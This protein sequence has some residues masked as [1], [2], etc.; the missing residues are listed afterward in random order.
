MPEL[1]EVE[2]VRRSLI[3][4]VG[5]KTIRDVDVF[6]DKMVRNVSINTLKE[7][8]TDHPISAIKRIGKYL[9]FYLGDWVLISHLRMEGRYFIKALDAPKDKHEHVIFYFRDGS[10]MRYHDTRKFGTF[11]LVKQSQLDQFEPIQKMG[12]EPFDDALTIDYLYQKLKR[13]TIAIKSALLDQQIIAGLGNIY[14]NEVL[15][16]S[17]L[18]PETPSHNCRK[19][20]IKNIIRY[21]KEILTEAVELGGTTIRSY[22]S[23]LGVTGR[24]QQKLNVHMKSI[25]KTCQTPIEKIKVNGRGTYYCKKC[26]KKRY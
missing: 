9:L 14:V 15:F 8:I 26:Q 21:S 18:H 1:P 10:T 6:V 17:Q 7:A 4:L 11:D 23:S 12:P 16:L 3:H 5:G 22:T 20:D 13:K 25:C 19:K 24:F 2:T